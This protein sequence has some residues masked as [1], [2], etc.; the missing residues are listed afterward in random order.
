VASGSMVP[1]GPSGEL[2]P[3]FKDQTP[4]LIFKNKKKHPKGFYFASMCGYRFELA[5]K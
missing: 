2:L 5:V 3:D 1:C 4:S